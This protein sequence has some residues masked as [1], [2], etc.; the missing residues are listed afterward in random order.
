MGDKIHKI[1]GVID[2][3]GRK[4]GMDSYDI[5]LAEGLVDQGCQ[6]NIYS[7]F[8]YVSESAELEC[9]NIFSVEKFSS[10]KGAISYVYSLFYACLLH[11]KNKG[12]C[13]ILHYFNS[14]IL[15]FLSFL[16]SRVFSFHVICILHDVESFG[17]DDK[18]MFRHLILNYLSNR[19]AIQ[20]MLMKEKAKLYLKPDKLN[21]LFEAAHGAYSI[22]AAELI[23]KKIAKADLGIPENKIVVLFFGQIKKVKGL[24]VFLSA[25]SRSS[26]KFYFI[27]AGNPWQDT[28]DS[29]SELL[30]KISAKENAI[31][32]FQYISNEQRHEYFCASDVLVLPYHEIFE[33]GVMHMGMSYGIPIVASNLPLFLERINASEG[34]ICFEKGSSVDLNNTL[35]KLAQDTVLMHSLGESAKR[36]SET[37]FSWL[38]IAKLYA[39]NVS[40]NDQ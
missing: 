17:N 37:H 23:D 7:N 32:D 39:N 27:V 25:A 24:E 11:K 26:D 8:E 40:L 20:N 2:P 30:E 3:V 5:P 6:V 36:Y 14:N 9:F 28:L 31:L 1:V 38:E 16:L 4:G 13:V 34:G 29:Y 33:S 22:E 12:N 18:K 15:T 35:E 10:L 19:I 21:K